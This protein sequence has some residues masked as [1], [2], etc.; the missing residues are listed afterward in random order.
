MT[1]LK[2]LQNRFASFHSTIRLIIL[3]VLFVFIFAISLNSF[4]SI[5]FS[6]SE[7]K[8]VCEENSNSS[9]SVKLKQN[10][11]YETETLPQGMNY[12]ASL[13]DEIDLSFEY[14]F[15]SS[16]LVQLEGEYTIDAITRVYSDDGKNILFEKKENLIEATP[17]SK[18]K[19]ADYSFLQDVVI[20]YDH[21]NEFAKQ[22]K[23]SYY[24]TSNSDLTIVLNVKSSA[25]NKNYKK[26]V[27]FDSSSIVTIPLTERT[28]N[29]SIG[30]DDLHEERNVSQLNIPVLI[31]HI[32][33]FLLSFATAL[34]LL[35]KVIRLALSMMR[36]KTKYEIQLNRILKEN[37]SIIANVTNNIQFSDYQIVETDSFEE[38]RDVHDNLGSPI[39]YNEISE[40]KKAYFYI[41]HG[42]IL[43]RY[44]LSYDE[45]GE[46]Q[47]EVI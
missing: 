39:L 22:F 24:I 13:I 6:P 36:E 20:D 4:V 14:L 2:N 5:F 25:S 23:T 35:S 42:N 37:D 28:I 38:L 17:F 16:E 34:Y 31:G 30:S 10:N 11:F 46:E 21:F 19:M 41:V 43:Y 3:L 45:L 9:Y 44:V 29:I 18:K 7:Y 32:L 33:L 8:L 40:G 26:S 12:I 47:V 27:D 1:I 15:S